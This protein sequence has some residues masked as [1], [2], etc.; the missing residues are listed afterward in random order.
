MATKTRRSFT[1]EFRREAVS[2]LEASGRPLTQVA[3]ELG[4][5]PSMLRNWRDGRSGTHP[6]T[7]AGGAGR[8]AGTPSAE[9]AEIRRLQKELARADGARRFKKGPRH[10]LGPAEMR[11]RFIE[12]HRAVFQSLPREGGG[13][14]DVRGA[15]GQR[16]R[17]LRVAGS[18]GEYTCDC[19]P[20]PRRG[21]TARSCQQPRALR[22]SACACRPARRGQAGGTQ[23]GR[24]P[25]APTR[26]PCPP[27]AAALSDNGQPPWPPACPQPAGAAVHRSCSGSGLAGGH[28]PRVNHR[29]KPGGDGRREGRLPFRPPRAGFTPPPSSICS[30]VGSSAGRWMRGS[31]RS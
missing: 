6:P 26:H 24:P 25:D 4:I 30:H 11:F 15:G 18:A 8:P 2:L 23:Q 21:H 31:P 19:Q 7:P 14:G 3:V 10:L 27:E 12:D 16:Q 9:Q 13:A 20:Q 17:L 1:D 22:Q 28:H 29:V 5:Q